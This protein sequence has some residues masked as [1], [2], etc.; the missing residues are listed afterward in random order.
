MYAARYLF[1][2]DSAMLQKPNFRLLQKTKCM[3]LHLGTKSI[4]ILAFMLGWLAINAQVIAHF[5]VKPEKLKV[6]NEVV[7]LMN[8]SAYDSAEALIISELLNQQ[9]NLS[10]FEEYFFNSYES[11]IMYYNALFEI[12]LASADECLKLGNA[13][14]NDTLIGSAQN[15]R[16]L[17][18]MHLKEYNAAKRA[19]LVATRLLPTITNSDLYSQRYHALANLAEV[20]LYK[21]QADSAIYYSALAV[22][23]SAIQNR[24]RG[25]AFSYWSW[26]EAELIKKNVK[27]AEALA[28]KGLGWLKTGGADDAELF[29]NLTLM[30]VNYQWDR[31]DSI[32]KYQMRAER[33]MNNDENAVSDFA[34]IAYLE[35]LIDFYIEH[36]QPELAVEALNREKVLQSSVLQRQERQRTVFLETFFK[37][38]EAYNSAQLKARAQERE[39][40]LKNSINIFLASFIALAILVL[41]VGYKNLRHQQKNT[42]LLHQ[43]QL[44][45]EQQRLEL[46]A[47]KAKFEAVDAERNRIAADLHD[48]IGAALSSIHIYSS[49]AKKRSKV[50]QDTS[51]LIE[52]IDSASAGLLDRMS[53]IIWSIN[54]EHQTLLDLKL[55][56]RS[57]AADLL[58][59]LGM[60]ISYQATD[61][62]DQLK[63]SVIARKNIYLCFKEL[64]NN[65]AKHSHAT[66]VELTIL[67]HESN[68]KCA[69]ADNG[70]GFDPLKKGNGNGLHNV[71]RRIKQIG[72][73]F[74]YTSEPG[75]GVVLNFSISLTNISD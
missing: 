62:D 50:N 6:I 33:L 18:L 45:D 3:R 42:K 34:K 67:C 64:I 9:N 23:E 74:F 58:F 63:L 13:L 30:K 66:Q 14:K 16:G 44:K 28:K 26:A 41:F 60:H 59:P 46:A 47:L 29:L 70:N 25:T 15:L 8:A 17:Q 24:V 49:V 57:F 37:N 10:P 68:L 69:I 51:D 40:V 11:E 56:I 7:R 61:A 4:L 35:F 19:F 54:P 55:R 73:E 52:K 22:K 2:E 72:G 39:I 48:E 27:S 53:D 71:Q 5:G 21:K 20:Y 31:K 65:I 12:G 38:R 43:S 75:K 32:I 1:F 36:Q